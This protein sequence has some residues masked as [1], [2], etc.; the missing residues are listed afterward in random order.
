MDKLTTTCY[1]KAVE[2]V[3]GHC[4]NYGMTASGDI[5]EPSIYTRDIMMSSLGNLLIR[6][7]EVTN[8]VRASI[9]LLSKSQSETGMIPTCI[10]IK[11]SGNEVHYV[12]SD[13]NLW[14]SLACY[15]YYKTTLDKNFLEEQIDTIEK[16]IFWLRCQDVDSCGLLET[17]EGSNWMDAFPQQHNVLSDNVLWYMT[18]KAVSDMEKSLGKDASIYEKLIDGLKDKINFFLWINQDESREK[19]IS[20]LF[21]DIYRKKWTYQINLINIAGRPYYIPFSSFLDGAD[22]F[23]SLG[24][25]L[26]I[27]SGMT[28][29]EKSFGENR[30]DLILNYVK[31]VGIDKPYP[32]KAMFPPLRPGDKWWK[33]YMKRGLAFREKANIPH[34]YHNGAIWPFIG[35]FYVA[36]LVRCKRLKEAEQVLLELAK[37]NQLGCKNEWG[38]NEFLHGETARPMGSDNQL[39]SASMFIYAYNMLTDKHVIKLD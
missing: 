20:R 34:Q 26:A 31:D 23:E 37:S 12:D 33:P 10:I 36:A 19:E 35:G 29:G 38:F 25:F 1:Q 32:V 13:P 4:H 7:K 27:L 5:Y 17:R 28:D 22:Y 2:V 14:H 15:W 18:L 16:S 30:S 11:R 6:D 3:K 39:W 9:E 24:N 21:K 8:A